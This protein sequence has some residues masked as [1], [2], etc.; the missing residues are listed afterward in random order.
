VRSPWFV[1][2]FPVTQGYGPSSAGV[3]PPGRGYAHY[4]T[5]IDVGLPKGTP[6]VSPIAG[7]VT[8]REN[9]GGFGHYQ[10]IVPDAAPS[11]TFILGHESVWDV[12][13]GHVQP[14]TR[15]GLSGSTGN[16]TGPH[17]HFEQDIGGPPYAN[18]NEVDPTAALGGQL[19]YMQNVAQTGNAS[20]TTPP[21]LPNPF[22]DPVGFLTSVFSPDHLIRTGLIIGGIIILIVGLI[23]IAKVPERVEAAAPLAAA[24]A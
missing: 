23:V 13:S 7:T 5:G 19:S 4:H 17:L 15:V 14:G 11:T 3:E 20:T 2:N 6:L 10:T 1:G 18:N 9:P 24:V 16:S 22:T 21:A 8:D 12:K